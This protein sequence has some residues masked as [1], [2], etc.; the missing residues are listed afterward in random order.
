MGPFG[1]REESPRGGAG[2]RPD[3]LTTRERGKGY[4][5]G[6]GAAFRSLRADARDSQ[7]AMSGLGFLVPREGADGP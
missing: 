4:S 5:Q 1:G 6:T 3:N 2:D 7:V